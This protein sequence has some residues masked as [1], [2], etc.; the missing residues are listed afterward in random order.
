MVEFVSVFTIDNRDIGHTL[1]RMMIFPPFLAFL[2][3]TVLVINVYHIHAKS[4][5]Y[6][7]R[8]I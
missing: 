2:G 8:H 7:L 5:F 1:T 4:H 3:D 6:G